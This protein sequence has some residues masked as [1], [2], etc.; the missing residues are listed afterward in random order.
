MIMSTTRMSQSQEEP[1]Q[2]LDE[3]PYFVLHLSSSKQQQDTSR[4][5]ALFTVPSELAQALVK[6]PVSCRGATFDLEIDVVSTSKKA[7]SSPTTFLS[8]E[9]VSPTPEATAQAIAQRL[10]M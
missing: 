7:A 8:S 1:P 6:H 10:G 9:F 4:A 3:V 2:P 5:K